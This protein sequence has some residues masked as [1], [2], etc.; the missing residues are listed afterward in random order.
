MN[1]TN[2]PF[3]RC[4]RTPPLTGDLI[5]RN[6]VLWLLGVPISVLLVLNLTGIL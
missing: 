5:M 2:A 1:A 3:A 6:V 4:L